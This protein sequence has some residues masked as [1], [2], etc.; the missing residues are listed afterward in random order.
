MAELDNVRKRAQRD[1]E[2]ANRYG[3]EK[4]AAE[5][6]PVRDSLELAVQ[7]ADR[8]EPTPE[9]EGGPGGDARSCSPRRW[10]GSGSTPIDPV[11]EP[12]DPARHEAMMAQES[13]TAE[14]NS[15][16]QVVQPGYELNGRLSAPGAGDRGQGLGRGIKRRCPALNRR[17]EHPESS[18]ETSPFGKRFWR[19]RHMAKVIGIDLGT[20]NSCVAIMEGGK[21]RV[22][23]NS[24]GDRTTPSIVAF[25][26]DNEVL[27]GQPAKRQAVTNP[28]NTLFAIKRLIGRKFDDEVVQRDI[29]MVP[30]KIARADNGDAWV[31]VQG[32]KMAPP[33]ISARVLMKMKKTAEDYLGE[34]VTE[35]VITVPAY[36]NDSQ[37][38]A[39]KDAGRI[40]G[41]EVKRII[42]EPTAAALAYGLDK[43]GG[44]R[45]IAVYDLGGGTFDVSIIEI[46]EV[47]GE[48][49]F[50]VLSTNGDTFLGGED[51]DL[52]IINFLAERVPEGVRRRRAQG[53]A[54][55]A[56]PEGGG[57]EGARSS[58]P[59][60]S[61]PT[62]TCRTSPR[63]PRARSTS[64]SS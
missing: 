1:I 38:Q 26:K 29:K 47:D 25:T 60:P 8:S 21:P 7:N 30:Y 54:R 44:D 20:T 11:G 62:S 23:E 59:R 51:F 55:H 57:G 14:P 17:R 50:E 10:R 16:L 27:V 31:E 64:T 3:L 41:L 46:A 43:Q 12:F 9:P 4:F 32:K 52:R 58:C 28:Q 19:S 49:Q 39:T 18:I 48:R 45:K 42:N 6:L 35:A 2:A 22:I 63:M 61:R 36:F 40:A 24:E 56:A 33:E 13:A 37:R 53:S 5:L 34:P 15:V